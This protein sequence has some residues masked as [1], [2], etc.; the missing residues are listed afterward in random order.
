M[1]SLG[2]CGHL[3]NLKWCAENQM[4]QIVE[5]LFCIRQ[6]RKKCLLLVRS[7]KKLT[8]KLGVERKFDHEE[9]S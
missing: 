9:K 2:K 7:E 4:K 1:E 8:F 5:K 6:L 3:R